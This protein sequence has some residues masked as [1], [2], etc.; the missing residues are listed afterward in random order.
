M[1]NLISSETHLS[2]SFCLIYSFLFC[3]P[4]LYFVHIP[5]LLKL[6]N[7]LV[8]IYSSEQEHTLD[9]WQLKPTHTTEIQWGI[10]SY[11]P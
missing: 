2:V 4:P 10:S 5:L 3:Q 11:C 7:P 6:N 9:E 8:S 1:T